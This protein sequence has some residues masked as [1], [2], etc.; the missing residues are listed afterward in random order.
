MGYACPV[1]EIPQ[2]DGEHLAHHLAFT[3]ML[4]GDEHE[5]WL[6][7]RVS[8]WE[9]A[10]PDQLAEAVV[11]DAEAAE[12]V[13]VFEDTTDRGHG[14]DHDHGGTFDDVDSASARGR[15]GGTMSDE[16]RQ[17]I[18]EAQD[19]T[20]EMYADEGGEAG[21]EREADEDDV[22]EDAADAESDTDAESGTDVENDTDA[23][24]A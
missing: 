23:D 18:E 14:H 21:D 3:A 19:L 4:H 11:D 16:T 13:E 8:D 22:D 1:C 24:D 12:Y 15:D 5:A 10:S 9:S 2:R 6:A 7:E 20:R 17:I